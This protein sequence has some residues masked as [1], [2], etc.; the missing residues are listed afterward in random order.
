MPIT[1]GTD[2]WRAI[3]ADEFTFEN[4]RIVVQAIANYLKNHNKTSRGIIIGYDARFL[5]DEFAKEAAKVLTANNISILMADRDT[6]TPALAFAIKAKNADGSIVFTASHNP[7]NYCGLKFI[8]ET[9]APAPKEITVEIEN[10]VSSLLKNK[11]AVSYTSQIEIKTFDP[12]E[13]FFKQVRKLVDFDSI[14]KKKL[15]IVY[16][17][18]YGSGRGYLDN[19]LEEAGCDVIRIRNWRDPLF[20]GKSP[21]PKASTLE[22]LA[23]KVLS[24]KADLGLANDGDADRY[25]VIDENGRYVLPNEVFLCIFN[26]LVKKGRRGALVKTVSVTHIIDKIA[27]KYGIK[28][29]ETPVGFKHIGEVMLKEDVLVG[30]EESSGFSIQGHIPEKDGIV[31]GMLLVEMMVYFNQPISKIIQDIKNEFGEFYNGR[32]DLH[33]NGTKEVVEKFRNN[34]P[35]E[36]AGIKIKEVIK[37]DGAKVILEDGSWFLIRPSGTEPLLRI[38]VEAY[39]PEKISLILP[40]LK[41][42]ILGMAK[43]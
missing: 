22:E 5:A 18:M 8:P 32:D 17:P 29:F 41:K 30:G 3:I 25:G 24:E 2:G 34:P 4:V 19:L 21:E 9:A 16:D 11:T 12:R 14:K 27:Q 28:V 38:Y 40:S 42:C 36:I 33:L 7:G 15:K 37:K 39:Q 23:K 13:D 26:Y 31:A 43:S 35:K 1:F 20:G 10:N 6:P